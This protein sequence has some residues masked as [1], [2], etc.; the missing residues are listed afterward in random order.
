MYT[1]ATTSKR[2]AKPGRP[3]ACATIELVPGG[4]SVQRYDFD[5][6]A[7]VHAFVPGGLPHVFR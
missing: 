1:C 4:F 7:G 2:Y 6:T 5:R 3:N